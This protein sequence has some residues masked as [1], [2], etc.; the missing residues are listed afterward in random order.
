MFNY[1]L[2]KMMVH[3]FLGSVAAVLLSAPLWL[4]AGLLTTSAAAQTSATD[5]RR[6][7]ANIVVPQLGAFSAREAQKPEVTGVEA[8]VVIREQSAVTTLDITLH[9]PSR[10]R[11]EAELW[12]PVPQGAVIRSFTFQGSSPEGAVKILSRAEAA[13]IYHEITAKLKDPAMLE[14]AGYGMARSTV[15]PIE[16]NQDQKV[17]V[18]YE[19]LLT[20][21][22]GR[23]DYDLLR[24]ESLGNRI[25]WK[26]SVKMKA[27]RPIS[28]AY[29]PSHKIEVKREDATTIFVRTTPESEK[30]PGPFRLSFLFEGHGVTSTLFASPDER[31]SGGYFMLLAG[32]PAEMVR[33]KDSA[34]IRREVLLVLDHSGSMAGVKIR[35][36]LEAARQTLSSLNENEYFNIVVFNESVQA[37]SPRPVQKT[38]ASLRAALGFIDSINAGG[39][40]NIHD[41]LS[42]AMQLPTAEECLPVMLFLTDGQPTVGNTSEIAIREIATAH[43]THH[44]RVF[45]FGVGADVNA[46]LLDK[47][48]SENR[49]SSTYILPG[50]A[51][52]EKV[53]AVFRRLAGPVLADPRIEVLGAGGDPELGRILDV[54]PARLPDLYD[55][56]QL[57]V[58]GRYNEDRPMT[59]R[60]SGNFLG[61]QASF[62]QKFEMDRKTNRNAFVSRLWAGRKIGLLV[63]EL[64]QMG[65][66]K[67]MPGFPTA[68]PVFS[69]ASSINARLMP[70]SPAATANDP[71]VKELV[72]EI[73]RLSTQFGIMT[74]YTAFLATEGCDLTK[75]DAVMAQAA[76][77]FRER[78]MQ[79]RTGLGALNQSLNANV[80]MSQAVLNNSN[81]F[82]TAEMK[83]EAIHTIQQANDLTFFLKEG[84]WIDSRLYAKGRKV[85]PVRSVAAGTP[86]YLSFVKEMASEG[87]GGFASLKG[88]AI[89]LFHGEPV[90]IKSK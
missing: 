60:I 34:P 52:E 54:L 65:A 48:S 46:P 17:R 6:M 89:V 71:R 81:S 19:H 55:G 51:V 29:S 77:A 45:A 87:R 90:L 85:E 39:S 38:A 14:F 88:D 41:A 9:N 49:G 59:I 76:S 18:T 33:R 1:N 4:P 20:V 26:I 2:R 43:N 25:P 10:S 7:A 83:Q 66:D 3:G 61:R 74:E 28:T 57:V 23:V 79:T 40:T 37:Y 44:R 13:G 32:P 47:I 78:A 67:V 15:F 22:A 64:R 73:L 70:S 84:K 42:E 62:T 56:D 16:A 21:N 30:E 27:L 86:E 50:E 12:I 11:T 24:S 36:M 53:A 58:L 82:Y 75:P 31:T 68:A 69:A 72:G 35:Q 80:Q 8:G 5:A 63:D